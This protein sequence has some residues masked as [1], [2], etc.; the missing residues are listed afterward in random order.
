MKK[1]EWIIGLSLTAALAVSGIAYA[2]GNNPLPRGNLNPAFYA[3]A[4][5]AAG[6]I[7]AATALNPTTNTASDK[8]QAAG[9]NGYGPGMMGGYGAYGMIGGNGVSSRYGMMDGY[10][11]MGGYGQPGNSLATKDESSVQADSNASLQ[12][13]KVNKDDNSITYTGIDVKLVV[14]G[15][16]EQA[17][18]QFV[19]GG[20]VN[21]TLRIPKGA[22]VT[23]EFANSDEGMPHAFEVTNAVP[24]YNYMSMMDGAIYPGSLIGVMPPRNGQYPVAQTIF[25]ADQPGTFYYICQYPGH[26]AKGM[27]G[28]LIIE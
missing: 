21:P 10:G 19:I 2:L 8:E 24:P 23:V 13:A 15:G 11:M 4:A 9:P 6:Q 12:N 20:L 25:K 16:P 22:T 14:L 17:D 26:A 18:D 7:N 1:V 5:P 3:N 28:K 27:Y